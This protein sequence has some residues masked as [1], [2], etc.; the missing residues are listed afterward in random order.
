MSGEGL[1]S[2]QPEKHAYMKRLRY[3]VQFTG[4]HT[5]REWRCVDS[6]DLK[7]RGLRA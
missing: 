3:F 2:N 1:S 7:L 6:I 5:D 4:G